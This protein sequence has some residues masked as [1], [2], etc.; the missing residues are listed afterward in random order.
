MAARQ[1]TV[2][3]FCA[4]PSA[5]Q[6]REAR[7]V[8][9]MTTPLH[10]GIIGAGVTGLSAARDLALA[11]H[12]VQLFE[13]GERAG[14]LAAGFRDEGWDWHL[15]KFYHHW[16]EGDRHILQLIEEMGLGHKLVFPR[17]KT[18]YWIDGRIYRAEISP[19]ALLLPLSPLA[20][21][22]MGLAALRLKM[23][24]D[25]RPLERLTAH[26]WLQRHMGEEAYQR[27][28][29][30]LLIGKF[31][32]RYRDVNMAWLWARIVSRSLRLGTFE[33][34]FQAF[35]NALAEDCRRQGA[36]IRFNTPVTRV[37]QRGER[38]SIGLKNGSEHRFDRVLSTSS[39][40]LM[41]RLCEGL[42]DSPYGRQLAA[43]RSIGG[44][45]VVL[46]LRR[47]LLTDGTYWLNLPATS[48]DRERSQFPFLALVEHS[49]WMDRRHY[50]GDI[51]VYCGDYV[52]PDHLWFQLDEEALVQRFTSALPLI[53][54][55][56]RPDWL[57]KAWVFRAPYAQ[58]VPGINHSEKIPDLRTPWP[59]LYL[60]NMSQVYPWDRGTNYAVEL[61]RRV[62]RL[63]QYPQP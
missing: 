35:L 38:L 53:N 26:D 39:P 60:A 61:G 51:L 11:G 45:C 58:P 29:Q 34:G 21:L 22:R 52:P 2:Y 46:A 12:H 42:A 20:N 8:T 14:G 41:L 44:V 37:A 49:N 19:S 47:S 7:P 62:A 9:T 27:L 40:R 1:H 25:W 28:W 59:G 16:F 56:Y 31:S 55:D 24:K 54:P 43:L 23:M 3:H 48:P 50:G 32:D 36:G 6:D 30:P 18:S 13:S 17:P 15:E 57:R 33:G 5:K 10:V 4:N 63:M